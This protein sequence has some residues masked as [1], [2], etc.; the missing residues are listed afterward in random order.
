[1]M[2]GIYLSR[3]EMFV[4][5][6]LLDELNTHIEA[7]IESVT[8]NDEPYPPRYCTSRHEVQT[9]RRDR[10]LRQR[11]EA[12]LIAIDRALGEQ[13]SEGTGA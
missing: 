8:I 12:F 1:M 6:G 9:L 4:L 2:A 13:E 11:S 10:R 7:A 5:Q 3:H